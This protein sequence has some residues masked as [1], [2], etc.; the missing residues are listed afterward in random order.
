MA[1][2]A[3]ATCTMQTEIMRLKSKRR[4]HILKEASKVLSES[5]PIL[6]ATLCIPRKR[7]ITISNEARQIKNRAAFALP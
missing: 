5:C 6:L 1:F 4:G 7:H 3:R 2:T